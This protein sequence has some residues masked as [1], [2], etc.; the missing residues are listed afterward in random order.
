MVNFD[1]GPAMVRLDWCGRVMWRKP[2]AF[3]HALD[4]AENGS[5]WTWQGDGSAFA[6]YQYLVRFDPATGRI[7][8]CIGLVEDVIGQIPQTP[9]IFG[10][11]PGVTTVRGADAPDLFHPDGVRVLNSAFPPAF[12]DFEVGDLLLSF[13]ALNLVIVLDPDDNRIK[14]HEFGPLVA[15]HDPEF[16]PDGTFSVINNNIGRNRSSVVIIEPK[17]RAARSAL[18][19]VSGSFYTPYQSKQQRLADGGMLLVATEE[20]RVMEFDARGNRVLTI[21]NR[22]SPLE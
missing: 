5:L 11:A 14:W 6:S 3:H 15:Q 16:L 2:G 10:L 1:N 22:Y 9:A 4:A 20:G 8:Q 21:T 19:A 7:L 13:R 17:T 18:N 12:P